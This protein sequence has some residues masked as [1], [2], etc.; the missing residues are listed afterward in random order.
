MD[1][2]MIKNIDDSPIKDN[3]NPNINQKSSIL[4]NIKNNNS[5]KILK[6]K[7]AIT[8]MQPKTE[9]DNLILNNLNNEDNYSIEIEDENE[10][11]DEFNSD[12]YISSTMLDVETN[13]YI[14]LNE[15]KSND[16]VSDI[17]NNINN[18]V[19]NKSPPVK[20]IEIQKVKK[21]IKSD[22]INTNL[23]NDDFIYKNKNSGNTNSKNKKNKNENNISISP[24]INQNIDKSKDI[25]YKKLN[26]K[27]N[28]NL[29]NIHNKIEKIEEKVKTKKNLKIEN[30]NPEIEK[31]NKNYSMIGYKS[32]LNILYSK[33]YP[34]KLDSINNNNYINLIK[35]SND[36][37]KNTFRKIK[38]DLNSI[39][40]NTKEKIKAGKHKRAP[41]MIT[42]HPINKNNNFN[43]IILK[44]KFIKKND[45]KNK[46]NN[47]ISPNGKKIGINSMKILNS[48]N[49][50]NH[51]E[52]PSSSL[53]NNIN[54]H[55]R[56]IYYN[57]N[58]NLIK[59]NNTITINNN[60]VI[61]TINL[62]NFKNLSNISH[63]NQIIF[64]P[65][66]R[67]IDKTINRNTTPTYSYNP[68]PFISNSINI[69]NNN[70][71]SNINNSN[72]KIS[73]KLLT[74][75][76][77]DQKYLSRNRT[78]KNKRH[79][80]NKNKFFNLLINKKKINLI[81]GKD[82]NNKN[83][84]KSKSPKI[85]QKINNL[86]K[87]TDNLIKKSNKNIQLKNVGIQKLKTKIGNNHLLKNT[88]LNS[89]TNRKQADQINNKHNLYKRDKKYYPKQFIYIKKENISNIVKQPPK[90]NFEI[91][92]FNR[93]NKNI[94]SNNKNLSLSK[95]NKRYL[96]NGHS[97]NKDKE[98]NVNLT[99]LNLIKNNPSINIIKN[100]PSTNIIK[101]S[102]KNKKIKLEIRSKKKNKIRAKTLMEED[103]L[104]DILINNKET[105]ESEN[106]KENFFKDYKYYKNN[107]KSASNNIS[108]NQNNFN[109]GTNKY[110]RKKHYSPPNNKDIIFKS[111]S[112]KHDINFNIN[113]NMNNNDYKKLIYY[114]HGH[115]NSSINY[116]YANNKER[117]SNLL[118]NPIQKQMENNIDLGREYYKNRNSNDV[119]SNNFKLKKK[120]D[121]N[122]NIN[123]TYNTNLNKKI[124]N[125]LTEFNNSNNF[126]NNSEN[127]PIPFSNN[128]NSNYNT[129]QYEEYYDNICTI[130]NKNK[131]KHNFYISKNIKKQLSK[132]KVNNNKNYSKKNIEE[133]ILKEKSKTKMVNNAKKKKEFSQPDNNNTLTGSEFDQSKSTYT[134]GNSNMNIKLSNNNS[135]NSKLV[136]IKNY[137]N[138]NNTKNNKQKIHK[139][140]YSMG[141]EIK[142]KET[143][144]NYDG[145]IEGNL[146]GLENYIYKYYYENE[147]EDKN[148]ENE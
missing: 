137:I 47:I 128:I 20:T 13:T 95:S 54:K 34:L 15:K 114:Y 60:N 124:K 94:N 115:N 136:K 4:N 62:N 40:I 37:K 61:S 133:K 10:E 110:E 59:N 118:F 12:E 66:K 105:K 55:N 58:N 120:V 71:I 9:R 82:L 42:G 6:I 99:S 56:I 142:I 46:R 86:K 130:I 26:I 103:Y 74:C 139:Q 43:D 90:K 64:S 91:N 2:F 143:N 72:N 148:I 65:L 117:N 38:L 78:F 107:N 57:T 96:N 138:T 87:I 113:I 146:A 98:I 51:M 80:N 101:N 5:F 14:D 68:N 67:R 89:Y 75:N 69:D 3:I 49:T 97:E 29:Q 112:E 125:N 36:L 129:N 44:N 85:K 144:E 141:N 21:F 52:T 35:K 104:K 93:E 145:Q 24:K 19:K 17:I 79:F 77:Q 16:S 122:H 7:K 102:I 100:T 73:D 135:E 132:R 121:I 123:S 134:K 18:K 84:S 1:K 111:P 127:I 147:N 39:N 70:N 25:L 11:E 28:Q 131:N 126:F 83:N 33:E 63:I 81:Y 45:N 116:S 53:A 8:N 88:Y 27:N 48:V 22:N 30:K 76:F 23:N 108:I 41:T 106:D 140:Q 92:P 31:E 109:T 119:Y 50:I 32:P